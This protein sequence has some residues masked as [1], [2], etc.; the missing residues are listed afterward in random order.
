M[1]FQP[2]TDLILPLAEDL[3][4]NYASSFDEQQNPLD[5]V[6]KLAESR[7]WPMDRTSS[8]EVVMTISGGWCNLHLSLYWRDDLEALQFACSYDLKVPEA[9]HAEVLRLLSL[10]NSRLMHGHFDFWSAEGSVNFRHSLILAGGAE[11]NDAQCD[12]L[13]RTGVEA[14]QRYFPAMQ[15]VIWAGQTADAALENAL[16]ETHGEA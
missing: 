3:M 8:D 15:F 4:A 12:M 13:I 9:R 11:A 14:C 1:Q 2:A 10:I 5:R 6:E 7:R 16:L